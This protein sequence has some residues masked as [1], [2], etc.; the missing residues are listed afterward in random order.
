MP[1]SEAKHLIER[2]SL[3][4]DGKHMTYEVTMEDP[5]YL[6]APATMSAQFDYRPDLMPSGEACDLEVAQR[7]QLEAA[8]Q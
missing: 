6:A 3:A 8:Q 1:S 4:E 7:Y 5:V 2:F